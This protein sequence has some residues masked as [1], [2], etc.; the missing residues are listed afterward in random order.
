MATKSTNRQLILVLMKWITIL[1]W[2]Y[3]LLLFRIFMYKT[4]K[5]AWSNHYI[6]H[7]CLVTL[8]CLISLHGPFI[9]IHVKEL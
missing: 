5:W 8:L 6:D 9:E 3:M 2:L 4:S 7:V 1:F